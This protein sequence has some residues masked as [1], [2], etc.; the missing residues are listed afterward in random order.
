MESML[1]SMNALQ[2]YTQDD[3]I[4]V[5]LIHRI[6]WPFSERVGQV[7]D[8][9]SYVDY[10]IIDFKLKSLLYKFFPFN[11]DL[12]THLQLLSIRLYKHV[13]NTNTV[14]KYLFID[15]FPTIQ[16][17]KRIYFHLFYLF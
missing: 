13:S 15:S 5:A 9:N 11:P 12:L 7:L 6:R 14:H 2:A 16:N 1:M 17:E 10:I 4:Q 8:E 3:D